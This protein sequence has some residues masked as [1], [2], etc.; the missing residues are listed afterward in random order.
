M[1]KTENDILLDRKVKD[2]H[3]R[4]GYWKT[5]MSTPDSMKCSVCGN[6]SM[7]CG[8]VCTHCHAIMVYKEDN[9]ERT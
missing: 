3:A 2:E 6:S 9:D 8:K 1:V 4:H 7:I 5:R